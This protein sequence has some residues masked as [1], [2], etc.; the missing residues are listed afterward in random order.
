MHEEES[1]Q[2]VLKFT[3][4]FFAVIAGIFIL[5]TLR[6]IFIP[7]V[8]AIFLSYLFAPA[9]E[10]LAKIKIPRILSLFILLAIISLIGA[11]VAQILVK[12]AKDF[13]AFW[14]TMESQII[15]N[16]GHIL[17]NYVKIDTSTLASILRSARVAEFLQSA[18]SFSLSFLGKT[19]LT[20]LI[21]IFIYLTYP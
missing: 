18:F 2:K 6:G 16:I 4:I 21:L 9:V 14:P 15:T 10:F 13:I 5:K 17:T 8:I 11:F 3:A 20:L 1:W 19:L 7:L 12:N